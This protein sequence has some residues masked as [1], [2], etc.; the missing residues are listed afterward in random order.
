M[1]VC[2]Y[3]HIVY[4]YI[5]IN[6]HISYSASLE[7]QKF[8]HFTLIISPQKSLPIVQGSLKCNHLCVAIPD[9]LCP[10]L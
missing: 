1:C 2:V 9:F 7:K 10:F 8:P 6:T 4:M 5:C 3:I